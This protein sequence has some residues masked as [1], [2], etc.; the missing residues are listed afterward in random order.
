MRTIF[1]ISHPN[2]IIDPDTIIT[3]WS[4][5]PVGIQRMNQMLNLSW[6][7]DVVS[8]FSSTEKKAVDGAKILA[9]HLQ[10][11]FTELPNLGE[12]DR[13]ATGYLPPAE[14]ELMA[15]QF[16]AAPNESIR[17]WETAQ[18]AQHRIV[19][20]VDQIAN[21]SSTNFPV[22]IVS[23][24]AVGTLL[25][26]HLKGWVIDRKHDQPGSGGGNYFR[27]DADTRTVVHGWRAID[28]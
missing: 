14:F 28:E 12:N 6:V 9:E 3:D 21:L 23:H 20:T 7:E 5:S 13:S 1:F 18:D 16:F 4:L 19:A 27:F 26:C 10:L 15:D 2:V 17:G 24:G 25:L 22:A 8:V 11:T